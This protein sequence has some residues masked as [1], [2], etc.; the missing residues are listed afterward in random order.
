MQLRYF[1]VLMQMMA[2]LQNTKQKY[3]R[4][5]IFVIQFEY[6]L[7]QRSQ[8]FYTNK[9]I[10]NILQSRNGQSFIIFWNNHPRV[11]YEQTK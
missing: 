1:T 11:N 7:P 8:G 6:D 3:D 2:I 9:T 5:A 10:K 4:T